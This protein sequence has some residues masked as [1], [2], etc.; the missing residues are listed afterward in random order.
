VTLGER[1]SVWGGAV[2]RGDT[3]EIT[4]GARSNIQDLVM[5]HADPGVPTIVGADVTV[6]HRAI[7]HGCR[8]EDGVLIGMGAI[9]LN[10][11]H[12][13]AGSIVGAGALV[14]EGMMVPPN[15][16]VLGMPAKVTRATTAEERERTV[17]SAARY[18]ERAQEHRSGLIVYHPAP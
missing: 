14:P 6:G 12:I 5:V 2:I 3:A 8:I 11:S 1:V 4:I 15:S 17:Q 18:G 9:L 7:L 10:R 16:L 13:G